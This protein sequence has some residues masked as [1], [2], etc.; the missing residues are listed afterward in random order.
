MV[1]PPENIRYTGDPRSDGFILP[2]GVYYYPFDFSI[3]LN[4]DCLQQ[5]SILAKVKFD[6]VLNGGSYS[7]YHSDH[8]Y[9]TLLPSFYGMRNVQFGMP[10]A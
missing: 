2:A 3:T 9:D 8:V 7:K 5:S 10:F 6:G 1:F 4:S